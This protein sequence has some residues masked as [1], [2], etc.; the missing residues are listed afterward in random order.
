MCSNL[1]STVIERLSNKLGD[2]FYILDSARFVK[3][4]LELINS[5][6]NIYPNTNIA[7]SYKTNYIPELCALIYAYGG[8]AE[9]VSDMEYTLAKRLG[10]PDSSIYFNGPYKKEAFLEKV[11][12]AGAHVNLDSLAEVRMILA[13]AQRYTD[14]NFFV[15]LRCNFDIG[16]KTSRFGLDCEGDEFLSALA[17]FNKTP[18][19]HISGLHCHFPNRDLQ[20]FRARTEKMIAL[21]KNTD[22][23]E[24]QY[25]SFGGGYLGKIPPE[26]AQSMNVPPATYAQYAEVIAGAMRKY[27]DD[28][29]EVQLIIEPGSALVA[30]TMSLVAR[31]VSTKIVRGRYIAT[32]AASSFNVNPSVKDVQRPIEVFSPK[33]TTQNNIHSWDIAGYTCIE[34]DILYK[35]YEGA[36][37]EG[38]IVVFYN[39]GSYSVVCKPPFILPNIPIIDIGIHSEQILKKNESFEDI[40]ST[41]TFFEEAY[42]A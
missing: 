3:N 34:D 26:L 20:S 18:N 31:V 16:T 10:V 8:Y 41:Y 19:I 13:L 11:L 9:V 6:R 35:G 22:F 23:P 37:G 27:F 7:Y 24:L 30:D 38:D 1:N 40:F 39:V 28:S 2:A 33:C 25:I 42:E 14:H 21:L 17:C 12:L 29:Q 4:Y 5:F 36:L 15:G 32:L